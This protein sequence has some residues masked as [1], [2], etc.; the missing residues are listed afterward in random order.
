MRDGKDE[1]MCQE[2]NVFGSDSEREKCDKMYIRK[3]EKW[4]QLNYTDYD[5]PYYGIYRSISRQSTII[6]KPVTAKQCRR[7]YTSFSLYQTSNSFGTWPK[8]KKLWLTAT[9]LSPKATAAPI[10]P[11]VITTG[12]TSTKTSD[13]RSS[14]SSS[15]S[16][17]MDSIE[18]EERNSTDLASLRYSS[19]VLE[20]PKI[21]RPPPIYT[22][23]AAW[24]NIAPS[25]FEKL[26]TESFLQNKSPQGVPQGSCLSPTLYNIYTNDL[27]VFSNAKVTLFADTLLYVKNI[28]IYRCI[29]K[30]QNQ[31]NTTSKW[32]EMWRLHINTLKTI[33]VI[34]NI[35]KT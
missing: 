4:N 2:Q 17:Q 30:F 16:V 23:S 21:S 34:I 33:A 11:L 13:T 19:L 1:K 3:Q 25:I 8:R 22:N 29:R 9:R 35:W 10:L 20:T 15:G 6:I 14:S 27:L 12:K 31:I 28:N 32:F 24:G 7:L 5:S 18:N 26:N